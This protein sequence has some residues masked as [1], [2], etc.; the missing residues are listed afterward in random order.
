MQQIFHIALL[1]TCCLGATDLAGAT[2]PQRDIN[3][4]PKHERNV[5]DF[6]PALK[7]DSP[8]PV[9]VWFHGGGF[10]NGDK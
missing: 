8:A 7:S 10:R 2:E 5:L 4:D 3:Y 9:H 1:L 6:W